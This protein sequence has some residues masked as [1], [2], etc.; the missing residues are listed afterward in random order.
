MAKAISALINLDILRWARSFMKLDLDYVA[1][2]AGIKPEELNE[3]EG[4]KAS[5]TISQLRKIAKVYKFSIAVFYLPK[6]PNLRIPHPRDRRLLPG[7]EQWGIS[8]ELSFEFRWAGERREIALELI[9]NT[10]A[11]PKPLIVQAS[12]QDAPE[13][14][15]RLLREMLGI[16][17]EEQ[18]SWH[19]ARVAL[20]AWRNRVEQLDILVFQAGEVSLRDMRG[21]SMLFDVLPIIGLNRKDTYNARSFTLLHEMTHLLLRMESLCDLEQDDGD[22]SSTDKSVEVFCNAVAGCTLVPGECLKNE[23]LIA[24]AI[25]MGEEGERAIGNLSRKYCVSREVIVRR[26]LTLELVD[27]RFYR[28]KRQKYSRE[29]AVI[30]RSSGGFMHPVGDA[31]SASGASFVGL[32]VENLNRGF[33]TT[34]DFS[35]FLRLKLKHLAQ[36]QD[37]FLQT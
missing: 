29:Y 24:T 2:K 37:S 6:P 23:G 33:I 22:I 11:K 18:T 10:G 35:N 36:I 9:E 32:V 16:T 12:I 17:Y 31:F 21:Y 3:W 27:E 26:M 34:S 5:P 20:N 13:S 30:K 4:G 28:I 7:F 1:E 15:G 25:E 8:P 14:V 19:D